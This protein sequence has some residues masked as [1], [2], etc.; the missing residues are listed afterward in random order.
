[1]ASTEKRLKDRELLLLTAA[2]AGGKLNGRTV[3][4]KL[5]YFCGRKLG[6]P[7]GHSAYFYGPYSDDFDAALKRG[8]LAEDFAEQIER[9]P[10]WH[11]GQDAMKH[12]YMLTERGVNEAKNVAESRKDEAALVSE[13]V[14]TIAAAVPGFRQKTLSAAA[15]IDLIVSEHQDPIPKNEIGRLAKELGWDLSESEVNEALDVLK[16]LDLVSIRE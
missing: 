13:T 4:Q 10:D 1:M 11:G 7:T 12:V 14:S 3:A 16:R 2:A 6:Q 5:L 9:I 15:K 8:V